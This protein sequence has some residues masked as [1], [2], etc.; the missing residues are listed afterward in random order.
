MSEERMRR[1]VDPL[2]IESATSGID[3]ATE[4]KLAMLRLQLYTA[5]QSLQGEALVQFWK[6]IDEVQSVRS[7]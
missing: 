4:A 7:V 6:L 1:E 5:M 3:P 2:G